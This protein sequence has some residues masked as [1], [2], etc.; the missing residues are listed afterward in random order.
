MAHF[1]HIFT[2]ATLSSISDDRIAHVLQAYLSDIDMDAVSVKAAR[3]HV[4]ATL[5]VAIDEKSDRRRLKELLIKIAQNPEVQ[6]SSQQMSTSHGDTKKHAPQHVQH[7]S[8]PQAPA[9]PSAPAASGGGA[10]APSTLTEEE[11]MDIARKRKYLKLSPELSRVCGGRTVA[12]RGMIV[13]YLWEYIKA[14]SLQDTQQ[15]S[16][17]N[18]DSALQAITP[19]DW[20]ASI[21]VRKVTGMF[22]GHTS[23]YTGPPPEDEI[24][25]IREKPPKPAGRKRA[26]DSSSVASST[27]SAAGRGQ[28]RPREDAAA[29]GLPGG[30]E[31]LKRPR[32][33]K[34]HK[35]ST[36]LQGILPADKAGRT[37]ATR[38]QVV[39]WIWDYVKSHGLKC[40]DKK[41]RVKVDDTLRPI[42]GSGDDAGTLHMFHIAKHIGDHLKPYD[43]PMPEDDRIEYERA[44]QAV[45]EQEAELRSQGINPAAVRKAARVGNDAASTASAGATNASSQALYVL[46]DS[47]C[48]VAAARVCTRQQFAKA[49]AQYLN[50]HSLAS[51]D[52]TVS[53]DASLA[54]IL[55][56]SSSVS[57]SDLVNGLQGHVTV[58][59]AGWQPGKSAAGVVNATGFS[60]AKHRTKFTALLSSTLARV[61]GH[62]VG[63]GAGPGAPASPL[64]VADGAG[65]FDADSG[66]E[67]LYSGAYDSDG[68]N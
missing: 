20:P 58:V 16:M 60:G 15:K 28:K 34:Y 53:P 22:S 40:Q 18:L 14:H 30:V 48:E 43:G 7:G 12:S 10:S 35:I 68:S 57:L 64:H 13:K 17:L 39:K 45:D 55:G 56:T 4:A 38:Q 50:T 32:A 25:A 63:S 26:D 47:L 6:R 9:Q 67:E 65:V 44:M 1:L 2:M 24:Q 31:L 52:G 33:N 54:R 62:P 41:T 8:G 11:V 37:I 29:A 51:R 27:A 61:S 19:P 66:M 46:D 21:S 36:A 5:K 59:P 42:L 23:E 49:L 3:L